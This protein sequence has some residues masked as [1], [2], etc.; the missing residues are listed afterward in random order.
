MIGIYKITSPTNR[1]YI[2]QSRNI[3][4]RK[5]HYSILFNVSSQRR[6]YNS[7]K[8]YGWK[9]HKF[10]IIEEC[11]FEDLNKKE[12]Y[13]Q[14]FY[15]VLSKNGL[16]CLL[17]SSDEKPMIRSKQSIERQVKKTKGRKGKPWTEEAKEKSLITRRETLLKKGIIMKTKE[18]KLLE[19]DIKKQIKA[20]K[21]EK[22]LIIRLKKGVK[23]Q[24]KIK[25]FDLQGNFIKEW[26][27][28][29]DAAKNLGI[30]HSK[31]SL[32]LRG[33]RNKAGR[34]KWE[35]DNILKKN[36]KH[37][38][39][40]AIPINKVFIELYDTNNTLLHFF[41]SITEGAKYFNISVGTI[42][43]NLK[44]LSKITKQGIWKRKLE[45]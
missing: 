27:S 7:L 42:S 4:K 26:D 35:T 13:W 3:E 31:I 11:L 22:P 21:P 12:R 36:K 38:K 39:L 17:T 8:K 6:L 30:S 29:K 5:Y 10:K 14:D 33:I 43:N 32:C 23:R 28:L 25:Q 41:E 1:V 20:N 44:G 18:E 37:K 9:A 19:K 24:V 15:N 16:N 2:G 34:F 40:N 45:N